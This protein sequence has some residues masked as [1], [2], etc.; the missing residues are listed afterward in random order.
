MEASMDTFCRGSHRR[1]DGQRGIALVFVTFAIAAFLIAIAGALIANSANSNA[2]WNYRGAEQAH[3][4]SESGLS[5]ALQRINAVGVKNFNTDIV[6]QWTT[7][8]GASNTKTFT[9]LSGFS[10]AVTASAGANP[11][12]TGRL[13]ST[14]RGPNSTTS[15]I[16]AN[17]QVSNNPITAPGAIYLATNATTGS[18]FQGNN[19]QVDGNDHNF[20]GGA[21]PAAAVPGITTR[22]ANNTTN[23][24]GA[25]A[26]IELDNVQGLGY[27]AGPPIVPSVATSLSAPSSAQI[28]DLI[29]ALQAL[30]GAQTCGCTTIN[31]SC[32][33]CTF[34]TTTTPKITTVGT[35][36]GA[37]VQVKSNGN[38]DGAGILIVNGNF[39]V[40]GT[41]NFKGLILVEG[42]LTVTGNATIYGSI[43]SEGLSLDVGG[44]AIVDYSSQAMAL[45]N[46]LVP[47]GTVALPMVITSMAD[48]ADLPAAT[49]GCP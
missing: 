22:N 12:T 10:Y 7:V 45:A 46:Q 33:T 8:W 3:F 27:Q 44:S 42:T 18:D 5:D 38:V 49:G 41:V 1:R 13:V 32:N 11:A 35:G 6:N 16:V 43:W 39:D 26:A 30:P 23:T 34:G 14:G 40:Q 20:T 36:G 17:L 29:N 21:G 2:S 19:F 15:I 4:V 28:G 24:I 47:I 31:N 48:C 37:T 25:L 9:A